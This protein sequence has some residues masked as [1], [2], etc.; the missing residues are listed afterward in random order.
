MF[1]NN[2]KNNYSVDIGA[3][4]FEWD[5]SKNSTNLIKH[6]ITFEDSVYAFLDPFGIIIPDPDHSIDE[7][8][9]ILIGRDSRKRLQVICHSYRGN[10]ETIRII[11][12][13]SATKKEKNVYGGNLNAKRI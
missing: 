12:V 2:N 4:T 13:R 9:F 11:S 8:R 7:E 10:E 6:G 5:T 3:I 1:D